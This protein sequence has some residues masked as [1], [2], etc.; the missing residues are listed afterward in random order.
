MTLAE[1]GMTGTGTGTG[2]VPE[3]GPGTGIAGSDA[4]A[5]VKRVERAEYA[6]GDGGGSAGE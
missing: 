5:P 2:T 6:V 3:T 1:A 4:V